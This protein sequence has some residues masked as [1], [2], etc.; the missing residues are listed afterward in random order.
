M[1]IDVT[2]YG[3]LPSMS[4]ELGA[5]PKLNLNKVQQTIRESVQGADPG[6][7][8]ES[9][10]RGIKKLGL[11]KIGT[12]N[13]NKMVNKARTQG[14]QVLSEVMDD[15]ERRGQRMATGAMQQ[16]VKSGMDELKPFLIFGGV[17][18]AAG[19]GWYLYKK[20]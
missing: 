2:A 6:Q 20:R 13:L 15:V 10:Q 5:W 9:V 12:P 16:T 18:A 3:A 7:M 19:L 1:S 11:N 8:R 14:R 17:L 4:S